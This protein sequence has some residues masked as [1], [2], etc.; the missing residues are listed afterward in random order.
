MSHLSLETLA[1]LVDEPAEAAEAAQW[2]AE[3]ESP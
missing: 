2:V 1:R 3:A